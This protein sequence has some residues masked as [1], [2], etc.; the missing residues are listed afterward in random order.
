MPQD[1]SPSCVVP[2]V[3][4]STQISVRLCILMPGS[5][6]PTSALKD[7]MPPY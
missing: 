6:S 3:C 7:P 1:I 2:A 5:C 4:S